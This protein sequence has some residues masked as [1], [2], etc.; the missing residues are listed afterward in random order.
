MSDI[1]LQQPERA[2]HEAED[3]INDF[4]V[5]VFKKTGVRI[6]KDDPVL[7]LL[8]LHEKIQKR[9][10]DLLKDDFTTLADA[11]KNVLSSLEEENIQRFRK[12]VDTCGDLDNEIK[13]AI[14]H[15]KNEINETAVLAKEKLNNEIIDIISLLRKNQEELNNSYNKSIAEFSKNTK[16]FSKSTAIALCVACTIGISAAF[17]GAFWYVAQSQKEQALQFYASGYMDMQKL[18]KETISLLP[19]EQQKIATAKLNALESRSR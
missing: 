16:P 10:S 5:D 14:E 13:E 9:Q 8:F 11:F 15:G 7:S 4:V 2:V 3:Q 18:T 19:K 6:S 17:S 1:E 12:I